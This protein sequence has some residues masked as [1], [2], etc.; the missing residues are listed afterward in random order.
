MIEASGAELS[1]QST[2]DAVRRGGAVVFVGLASE[3]EVPL[4]VLEIIDNEIDIHG[5]FRYKNTYPTAVNLLA[6]G[7]VDVESV[8]NF[9]APLDEIDDSFRQS[10]DPETVKGMITVDR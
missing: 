2:L 7:T 3:A 9:E 5:S 10:M 4:D 1:I 8:I 6:D